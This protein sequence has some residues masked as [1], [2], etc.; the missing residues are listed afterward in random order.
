MDNA[1]P[2]ALVLAN[3][4]WATPLWYLQYI[5]GARPDMEVRYVYPEGAE[6][7][8][9]TWLRRIEGNIGKR[10]LVVTNYYQ[11]FGATPYHFVPLR[12]AF[13]VQGEPLF[14]VPDDIVR[15]DV[16]FGDKVRLLGYR[17]LASSVSPGEP[18]HLDLHWQPLVE[19][20]GNYSFFMHLIGDG[21]RVLG[22][23]DVTHDMA[24]YSQ[25][26][27][28]VDRYEIRVLP[29][30][31]SGHY[32][33]I[34]G[35]YITL[36]GGGWRRL[37]TE[38]GDE[39]VLLTE[40][41]VMPPASPPVTLHP[42]HQPFTNGLTLIGVDYDTTLEGTRRVYL[43]WCRLGPEDGDYDVLLYAD[44][45]VVTESR[46]PRIPLGTYLTTAHDLPMTATPLQ[47][48]LRSAGDVVPR[49][50]PWGWPRRGRLALP[51]PPPRS[52]YVNLGGEML[53]VGADHRRLSGGTARVEL[54][55]VAKKPL[56]RDYVVSVRLTDEAGRLVSQDDTVPALG[57]IP[58]L[59]WIRGS[60][61][62]DVHFLPLPAG[63]QAGP[64][65]LDLIVY[66]AFTMRK[67][68]ILD[69]RLAKLGPSAP[70]AQVEL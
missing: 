46:L 48:E 47:I 5:E 42:L 20:E 70:L 25:G 32:Q 6:P 52:R 24:G 41:E 4:H 14:D 8:S 18:L 37:T 21:G 60:P 50:G 59:K 33:L 35:M 38:G 17:L 3:W 30:T 64:L 19:L 49:L 23:M 55:L 29:T 34:V 9:A 39:T 16:T 68:A 45:A 13:L 27:V 58:T 40:V 11:E 44:N 67:L 2:E 62:S 31:P 66:D 28:A 10:P 26:E 57:A 36:P 7:I 65:R 51:T 54:R 43:H 63:G 69:D 22:Q 53:L 61:V 15:L 56:L 1:P 12:E